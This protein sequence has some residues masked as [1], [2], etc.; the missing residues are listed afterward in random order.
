MKKTTIITGAIILA[1]VIT[2]TALIV[3]NQRD[4][5]DGQYSACVIAKTSGAAG[6]DDMVAAADHCWALTYGEVK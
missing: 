2:C 6:V 4:I 5:L 1:V 3:K